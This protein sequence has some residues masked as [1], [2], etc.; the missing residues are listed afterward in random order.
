MIT[1]QDL[2]KI[3][4]DVSNFKD[5]NNF[6][7]GKN[8]N[9]NKLR[10]TLSCRGLRKDCKHA[11]QPCGNLYP[12]AVFFS[13]YIFLIDKDPCECKLFYWTFKMCVQGLKSDHNAG[14]CEAG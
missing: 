2:F 5:K 9:R 11:K 6:P 14:R 3:P 12:S 4:R 13:K 1:F 10:M 8:E 7:W